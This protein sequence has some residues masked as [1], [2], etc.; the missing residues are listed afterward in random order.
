MAKTMGKNQHLNLM[1]PMAK[2]VK[3]RK[4]RP[5]VVQMQKV[6]LIQT[7]HLCLRSL[8]LGGNPW[9]ICSG[10]AQKTCAAAHHYL[11]LFLGEVMI[12]RNPNESFPIGWLV[13]GDNETASKLCHL[14]GYSTVAVFD[15]AKTTPHQMISDRPSYNCGVYRWDSVSKS[16]QYPAFKKTLAEC[17]PHLGLL[18]LTCKG[19]LIDSCISDQSWIYGN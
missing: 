15:T 19:K 6:L 5:V 12:K 14:K 2:L 4:T 9:F 16:F 10:G 17:A 13:S 1:E 8:L 7:Q 11:R 3:A 18:S